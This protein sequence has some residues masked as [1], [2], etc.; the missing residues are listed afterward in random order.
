MVFLVVGTWTDQG[1][2]KSG[3]GPGDYES[4]WGGKGFDLTLEGSLST[5]HE[6]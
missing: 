6:R 2:E 3:T 5:T 1:L 4:V